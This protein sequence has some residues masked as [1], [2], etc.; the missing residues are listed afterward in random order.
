MRQKLEP[1]IA[2]ALPYL[3]TDLVRIMSRGARRMPATPADAT[4]TNKDARG[5]LLSSISRPPSPAPSEP[6]VV[7]I[8]SGR[9][10]EAESRL[11]VQLSIV[12][13]KMP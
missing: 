10:S 7:T 6:D 12:L 5:L 4:A 9:L 1:H 13:Y 11:R 3:Q 2:P 8:G